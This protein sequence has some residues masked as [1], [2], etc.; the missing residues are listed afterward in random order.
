MALSDEFEHRVIKG[1]DIYVVEAHHHALAAWALVRRA[2]AQ[3]PNLITIDHHTDTH[4]AFLGYAWMEHYEHRADDEVA[5]REQL[6]AQIDWKEDAS[7]QNAIAKL[8]HDE[9][10]SAATRS[11]VLDQAYCI[12][13]SD[14]DGYQSLEQEAF[15]ANRQ[16]HWPD[17]PTLPKPT[18]P[19]TYAATA[20]R[21]YVIPAPCYIGCVTRPHNDDC[22]TRHALEIIEARYLE[23]Q[24]VRGSEISRC[25]GLT[26][27]EAAPYIL[28]ID[29][30]AFHSRKAITPD[31]HSTLHRLIRNAVAITIATE[32]ECVEEL[33][34]DEDDRMGSE[35][36][37]AEL[38]LHIEAAL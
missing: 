27:L 13:L 22:V 3:P 1:K 20:E 18:R 38:I 24:L 2:S 14:N 12:Q 19:M 10:I 30:D 29:L 15:D 16:A 25:F 17:P 9:H 5:L 7:L 35:D 4:E 26:G 34:H 32:P 37:L 23:D 6:T 28:D 11:G 31:D 21:I 36:L 8:R 33:W